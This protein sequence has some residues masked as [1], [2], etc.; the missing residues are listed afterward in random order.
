MCVHKILGYRPF[1]IQVN[2]P[3]KYQI[4]RNEDHGVKTVVALEYTPL[5]IMKITLR[6]GGE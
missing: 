1:S 3:F 4:K 6:N 5:I 2:L